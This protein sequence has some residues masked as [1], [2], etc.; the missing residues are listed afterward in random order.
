MDFS[1]GFSLFPF[2]PRAPEAPASMCKEMDKSPSL[3]CKDNN[4]Q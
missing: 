2:S 3:A 4:T 1:A